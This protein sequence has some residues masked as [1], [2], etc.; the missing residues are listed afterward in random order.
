MHKSTGNFFPPNV[1]SYDISLLVNT[2]SGL[3]IESTVNTCGLNWIEMHLPFLN[4]WLDG[5][6]WRLGLTEG[7]DGENS[8][9]STTFLQ[10]GYQ[11][12]QGH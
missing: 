1:V 6:G 3:N 7:A 4:L 5:G 12:D 2:T 11:Q 10:Q 8:P 9:N